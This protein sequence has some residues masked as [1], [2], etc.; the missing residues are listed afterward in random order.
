MTNFDRGSRQAGSRDQRQGPGEH[1]L[2]RIRLGTNPVD[3]ALSILEQTKEFSP[4]QKARI[5][6]LDRRASSRTPI[7]KASELINSLSCDGSGLY[8]LVVPG[9]VSDI[10]A[11]RSLNLYAAEKIGRPVVYP[12]DLPWY[13]E[14]GGALPGTVD[15]R[16]VQVYPVVES[17]TNLSR[18]D[19]FR[20][21]Q[22]L[23]L[24]FAHAIDV[25]LVAAA[26]ACLSRGH[27]LLT[28]RYVSTAASEAALTTI[29]TLGIF[30]SRAYH[31][32]YHN[33]GVCAAGTPRAYIS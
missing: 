2:A 21:L 23:N 9:G 17:T 1:D 24:D 4:S 16:T 28:D 18:H 14:H 7:E 25:A 20:E 6:A 8:H 27:D 5:E 31:H 13:S 30:V 11:L 32:V 26:F 19:Q 12:A 10:E 3:E 29:Q 22:K 15:G 33:L